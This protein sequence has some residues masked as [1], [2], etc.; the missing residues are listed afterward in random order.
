MLVAPRREEADHPGVSG[1]SFGRTMQSCIQEHRLVE[2]RD[3]VADGYYVTCMCCAGIAACMIM[4]MCPRPGLL[5]TVTMGLRVFAM[6]DGVAPSN[7]ACDA[8]ETH[9][10]RCRA[11]GP[12]IGRCN[13]PCRSRLC[14]LMARPPAGKGAADAASWPHP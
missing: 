13:T 7:C 6:A 14:S 11:R 9:S 4:R 10:T 5:P 8:L 12:A 3:L 2:C 1:C